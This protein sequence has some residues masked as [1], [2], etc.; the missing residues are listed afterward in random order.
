[1]AQVITA[2]FGEPEHL[3]DEIL[4]LGNLKSRLRMAALYLL[5]NQ[6]N[7][8]VCGTTNKS[9]LLTGYYTKNGDG[10]AD[11]EPIADVWKTDVRRLAKHLEIPRDIINKPPTAG[12]W[13]G[14]TDEADL[15]M[16]Y[17]ELDRYLKN[18]HE[19]VKN[20]DDLDYVGSTYPSA[21]ER[22]AFTRVKKLYRKS[23]H[24]RE[25]PPSCVLVEDE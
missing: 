18:L 13:Q 10:G 14:Q 5:A 15:G 22:R 24:K 12:L 1:M 8:L 19:A 3:G 2:E 6:E 23:Q 20:G 21:E 9:E 7:L 4:P 25:L 16:S 11:I 17:D